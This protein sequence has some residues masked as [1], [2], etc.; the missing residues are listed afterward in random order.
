[1]IVTHHIFFVADLEAHV[2]SEISLVSSDREMLYQMRLSVGDAERAQRID[3]RLRG[4]DRGPI[5]LARGNLWN[6]PYLPLDW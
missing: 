2:P 1:M 4:R 3:L 6:L 5:L